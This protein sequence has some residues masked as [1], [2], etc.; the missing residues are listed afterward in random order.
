MIGLSKMVAGE[1]WVRWRS[2][3]VP[4]VATA[5]ISVGVF[6]ARSW[7]EDNFV[8]VPSLSKASM[9]RDLK[10]VNR[11]LE[12]VELEIQQTQIWL[13]FLPAE[14]AVTRQIYGAQ[15]D[16]LENEH[17]RLERKREEAMQAME[18]SP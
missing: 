8:T 4:A 11:D 5:I 9:T 13:R 12:K 1:L 18:T 3:I 14:Q 17:T 7:A 2:V 16:V 6:A 15:L 10:E